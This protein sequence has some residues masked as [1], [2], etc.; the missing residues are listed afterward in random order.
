MDKQIRT[1]TGSS[2]TYHHDLS[3]SECS[4]S[5]P[6]GTKT[7]TLVARLM[8]LDLL[9]ENSSPRPSSSSSSNHFSHS[10]SSTMPQHHRPRGQ[11][12]SKNSKKSDAMTEC[13]S[14]P[15][16][17]RVSSARKS[18]VDRRFSLQ[19]NKENRSSIS[20]DLVGR[21]LE[22]SKFLATKIAANPNESNMSPGRYAKQIVKQFKESV[23]SRRV[24]RDITNTVNNNGANDEQRRDQHIVLLKSKKPT[25]TPDSC[26]PRLS[27]LL[28]TKNKLPAVSRNTQ[29]S[30][31]HSPKVLPLSPLSSP[32]TNTHTQP[33]CVT[34]SSRHKAHKLEEKQQKCRKNGGE[35]FD[36]KLRRPLQSSGLIRN[37]QEDS[38]VRPSAT[39]R[40]AN[41]SDYKKCKKTPL[42]NHV[43]FLSVRKQA[44]PPATKLLQK[45]VT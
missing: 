1:S 27:N 25:S 41:V 28:E 24:G 17:P 19:S 30:T 6:A 45:Q 34:V 39:N 12:C 42:S 4:S 43:P 33:K 32:C 20:N 15:E 37:K 3:S 7:P 35:N 13:R 40:A 26:S 10:S 2:R 5:S 31:S 29:I 8:G 38:F 9:P 18:D 11:H 36:P 23:N 21:E 44:C 16:T 14:L 22:F